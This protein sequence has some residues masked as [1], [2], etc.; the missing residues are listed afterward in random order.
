MQTIVG[1]A[2]IF[3]LLALPSFLSIS[4]AGDSS[5]GTPR[6]KVPHSGGLS[7]L[8]K[9]ISQTVD[10][11]SRATEDIRKAAGKATSSGANATSVF[12]VTATRRSSGVPSFAP[13]SSFLRNA[14]CR[15]LAPFAPLVT[16][17]CVRY[18]GLYVGA[19]AAL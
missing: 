17:A 11:I 18:P 6:K 1:R 19:N 9:P 8:P 7:D 14:S 5:D 10:A 13:S 3:T 4:S 16:E 2:V 12:R 15:C